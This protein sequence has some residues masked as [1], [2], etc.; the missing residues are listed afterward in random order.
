[1]TH[2]G[3]K[4]TLCFGCRFGNSLRL[5]ELGIGHFQIGNIF[6]DRDEV[7]YLAITISHR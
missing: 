2:I 4:G 5:M 3:K 6:L 7:S 1:M